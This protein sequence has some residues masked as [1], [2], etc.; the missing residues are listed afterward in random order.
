MNINRYTNNTHFD[1]WAPKYELSKVQKYFFDPIHQR[2]IKLLLNSDIKSP[3]NILDVGCG[4]GRLL[5]NISKVWPNAHFTGIDVSESMIKTAIE[6]APT[7]KFYISP[8]EKL[9]LQDKTYDIV[10]SSL[11]LH[12]WNDAEQ[13]VQEI[14]RV[15]RHGGVFC[16][17]DH[18]GPKW[19]VQ[20]FGSG[21]KSNRELENIYNRNGL[22]IISK[23][24][25][26]G[27]VG[28]RL[29]KK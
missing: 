16:L 9:P 10:L 3:L 23:S 14:V 8:A 11:T 29:A 22:K 17:A 25:F 13:G 18:L 5:R 24:W 26:L 4:T 1:E 2:M 21:T 12:H 15:L 27:W 19:A 7:F 28:I 6:L 20:F